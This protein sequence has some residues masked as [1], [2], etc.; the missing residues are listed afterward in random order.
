MFD[1]KINA[2][3]KGKLLDVAIAGLSGEAEE[4]FESSKLDKKEVSLVFHA[5]NQGHL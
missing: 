5:E 4:L 3:W 1:T 2:V